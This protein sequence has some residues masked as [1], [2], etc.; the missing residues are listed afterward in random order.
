MPTS[1]IL[2]RKLV[3]CAVVI[4]GW[5]VGS[6]TMCCVAAVKVDSIQANMKVGT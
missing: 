2:L 5:S 3:S 4:A 6:W 1:A